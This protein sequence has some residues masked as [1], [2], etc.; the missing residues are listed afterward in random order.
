VLSVDQ[1]MADHL[2]AGARRN[3][4]GVGFGEMMRAI[5]LGPRNDAE[6]RALGEGTQSAG[7]YTV[8]APLASEYIDRLRARSSVMRAGARTV[9]MDSNTLQIA[10]LETDPSFSF[11]AE[12]DQMSDNSPTMDA[13]TFNAKTCV[14][15]VRASQELLEDTVNVNDILMDAFA[16]AGA[17]TV[18]RVALVGSGS[19]QEPEGV[20]TRTDINELTSLG[21]PDYDMWLD[22]MFELENDD[23]PGP[24]ASIAHP[25]TWKQLRKTKDNDGR[26]QV[27]PP[28][29]GE[30]QQFSTTQLPISGSPA[31]VQ[32]LM[33]HFPHLYMGMRRE[34]TVRML[35]ERYADYHQIGFVAFLRFDIQ[36][37]H[38]E[39]F[40]ALRGLSTT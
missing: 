12:N 4:G 29:L 34:L 35:D 7:G 21:T 17:L 37:A 6:R 40:C 1:R 26:Y 9:P 20:L 16:Q 23:V 11:K 22:A 27:P 8:P 10:R 32:A 36:L 24:Y 38:P 2:P 3:T 14:S 15:L 28:V 31:E 19:G 5:A 39:S 30:V 33:G 25:D 18:D 13:I